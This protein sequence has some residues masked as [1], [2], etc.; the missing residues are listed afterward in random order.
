MY[1]E[2]CGVEVQ[3]VVTI[4]AVEDGTMQVIEKR[5]LNELYK[6]LQEYIHDFNTSYR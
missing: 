3:K 1:Y 6:L 5:N 2:R 4:I